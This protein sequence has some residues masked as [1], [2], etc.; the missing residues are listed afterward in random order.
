[1]KLKKG[2]LLFILKLSVSLAILTYLYFNTDMK[3]V[4]DSF[5]NADYYYF[6]AAFVFFFTS[7]IITALKWKTV[8]DAYIP[9]PRKKI[10]FIHWASDFINLFG[11]GAVGSET[12]KM[13]SFHN[14]KKA[15]FTSLF[16]KL[17]S[18]Y[19]Y[20]LLALS[21]FTSYIVFK[22]QSSFL[23]FFVGMVGYAM[24]FLLT[25]RLNTVKELLILRIPIVRV[26]EFMLKIK[27]TNKALLYHSFWSALLVL[28][29]AVIYLIVFRSVALRV[30]VVSLIIFLSILKFAVT[31]PIS[32]EGLGVRE[33][34]FVEFARITS[35]N[36]ELALLVSLISFVIGVMYRLSGIIPFLF[37]KQPKV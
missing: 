35:V 14:K 7:L 15:L 16:D 36:L 24:L 20:F 19:W 6:F 25:L 18:F 30:D 26:K 17:L 4:S 28:N 8:L 34:L 33:F 31:L 2:P 32:F 12:Y 22:N 5:K 1:M 10:I 3:Q 11:L 9:I 13:L 29:L 37:F 27:I 21:M 23:I